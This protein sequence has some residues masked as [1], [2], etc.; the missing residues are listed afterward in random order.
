MKRLRVAM[1]GTRG[2][3]ATYGGVERAVEELA[4]RIAASGHEVTVYCRTPYSSSRV[5]EYRGVR[6]RYLPAVDSKHLEA[7]SHSI[8]ATLD[9]M[10]RRYDIVHYHALGP[11]LC[12]P[13]ARLARM[14]VV[15]TVHAL[16]FRRAK[17]GRVAKLVLRVGAWSAARVPHRTIVVS[18]GLERY[19]ASS[20]GRTTT[21]V[22][23]GVNVA[24]DLAEP[25]EPAGDR[26]E[27]G[28]FLFLGRLVPEKGV[29]T[30]IEAYR[31]LETDVPLVIAGPSSHTDAYEEEL[32]RLSREDTRIV[33][34][35]PVYDAAKAELVAKTYAFCQPS[36][37]EG[38]PIVLLE[39][40]GEG[41]CPIV[42]DIAEHLEVVSTNNSDPVALV[43]RSGDAVSLRDALTTALERPEL[44]GE[45]GRKAREVVAA[46]Y[47]WDEAAARVAELYEN[48]VASRRA[49]DARER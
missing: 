4:A 38:L 6:L 13:L 29:H 44:V 25:P 40:M 48:L 36:T 43:F 8:L 23:N 32:R 12:A 9:A 15:T 33:F 39:M 27:N 21:Y 35:G 41:I 42:S 47:S 30:L 10:V 37:L 14:R 3:P 31:G 49:D 20:Y 46:R 24:R 11:G 5:R 28:H 18:H 2:M 19:F 34:A 7:L 17:W 22:P 16:D 45:R 1:I 26:R